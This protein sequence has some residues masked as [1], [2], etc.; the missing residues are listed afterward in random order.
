VASVV[1][2]ILPDWGLSMLAEIDG[3]FR[4]LERREVAALGLSAPVLKER[5]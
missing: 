4:P 1:L 5:C 3:S 2:P